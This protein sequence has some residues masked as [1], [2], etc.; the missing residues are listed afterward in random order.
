VDTFCRNLQLARLG[1][2]DCSLGLVATGGFNGLD[3]LD[4]FH[5][6]EDFAEDDVLAVEPPRIC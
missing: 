5:S 3:S 2:S 6:L 4:D 1:D